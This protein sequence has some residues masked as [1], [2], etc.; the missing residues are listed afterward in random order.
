M[1]G[2]RSARSVARITGACLIL[3]FGALLLLGDRP[4]RWLVVDDE[5][6]PVD[7]VMVL[8]GDPG[9][10]RTKTAARIVLAGDA[11]LLIVTG[12][13]AGPGDHASTLRAEALGLGVDPRQI[14]M[15]TRSRSTYGAIVAVRAILEREQIRT[16]GVV[17]SPYHSRR[18][19]LVARRGLPN[20]VI[21]SYPARP[22]Y[23]APSGWLWDGRSRRIV[24]SE[25]AKLAGYWARGWL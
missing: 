6:E 2:R 11:G 3:L 17:T 4:A 23:W 1:L 7:A 12:G 5:R 20:A 15:E 10:E 8:A 22:S 13:E 25:Y 16:L 24:F 18:A 14:R 21:H 9:Y 19:L